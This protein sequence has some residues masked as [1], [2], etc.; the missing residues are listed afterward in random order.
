MME[1]YHDIE[2]MQ[3]IGKA[4]V[5]VGTFDGIHLAH[6]AILDEVVRLAKEVAGKS[7]VVTFANHPR[8]VIDPDF[9]L[10]ILT[11][12]EE[13]NVFFQKIGIDIVVYANFT[14]TFAKI[15]YSDFIKF[16]ISKI[17][18]QKFVVGYNHNF[19]KNKEGN[20]SNLEKMSLLHGFK[21][22]KIPQQTIDGIKISSSRIR[23]AINENNLDL[24]NK[25]LGYNY[26][27]KPT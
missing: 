11:S 1:I 27:N 25:L 24:A 12:T 5:T 2:L 20:I 23:E 3:F 17:D 16:L 7:V 10:K 18:I 9:Q 13:K 4:V 22:V 8:T 21:V 15:D 14:P 26:I 19:G 6:R